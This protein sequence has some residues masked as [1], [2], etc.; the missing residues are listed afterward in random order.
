VRYSFVEYDPQGPDA[1]SLL[2]EAAAEAQGLYPEFHDPQAPA[3]TNPP[4]PA[5]GAYFVA[6]EGTQA[7]GMG[8]HR[9]LDQ[10]TSEVRRMYVLSSARRAGLA[11][12]LLEHIEAHAR[13][14]GFRRLVLETGNRQ[15]P[16]MRLYEAS[17]FQRTPPFGVY[18]NDPT[19]VCYAKSIVHASP[20][21]A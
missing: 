21:E 19:S 5:R 13:A 12:K 8:A 17:G 10:E 16:A 15:L 6:Y 9:P 4:T 20:G 14:Q 3:P 1:L 2:Q 11:R 7:I 18:K